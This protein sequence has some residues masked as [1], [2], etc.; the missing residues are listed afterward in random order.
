MTRIANASAL[1]EAVTGRPDAAAPA[2]AVSHSDEL[3][4]L[5]DDLVSL[6]RVSQGDLRADLQRRVNDARERLGSTLE[7]GRELSLRAREQVQK[8]VDAS[9]EA[10]S[11]RPLSSIAMSVAVGMVLGMLLSRRP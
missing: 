1:T 10:I 5:L 2:P 8:G 3:R 11:H 4:S 9:R 7:Q 6:A